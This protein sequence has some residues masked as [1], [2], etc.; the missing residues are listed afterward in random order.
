MLAFIYIFFFLVPLMTKIV[1]ILGIRSLQKFKDQQLYVIYKYVTCSNI[2]FV[3]N[4]T[5]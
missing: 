2:G 1:A 5:Y 4:I 3:A